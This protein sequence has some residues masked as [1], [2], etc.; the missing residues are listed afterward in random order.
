MASEREIVKQ[1]ASWL[2]L[3]EVSGPFLSIPVLMEAFP[4]GLEQTDQESELRRRLRLAYDEW[5]DNQRGARPERAI[6]RAWLRFVLDEVLGFRPDA[7]LEGQQIP[8][9]LS[10]AARDHGETVRPDLVLQSPFERQ[11]RLLIQL[12]PPA[13]K[14]D[15]VVAEQRWKASPAT[16]MMELL[17]ASNVRLGLITNGEH[18]MLIDAPPNETTGYYSWYA[19]LWLEEPLTLRAFRSLLGMERF[20]NVPA[21]Q[22]LEQL[23]TKSAQKQQEVTDQLGDQ[24]R[25]AVEVLVQTLDRLD[26]DSQ[27]TLLQ[28]VDEKTLYEAALTVM[29]RLVFLLSAEERGL[30]LLGDPLYDENYAVSTMH[31]QLR[32]LADQHGE[33]VLGLRHDAWSRLLALFR[34]VYG[35][36]SYHDL[37][38]PAYGGHLFDPDRYAFLEGR[39]SGTS[40]R[41]TPAQPLLIDNRTVLH[42]LNALQYLQVR[43]AGGGI[44]PRRL[45]FRGL[46]IEQIGHVYEGLLDH[47]A[48]RATTTILGLQGSANVEPEATLDELEQARRKG[49]T[50]LLH[51]L[52]ERTRLSEATVQKRLAS[53]LN[54][55]QERSRLMEACDNQQALFERVLPFAGLLRRDSF[56]NFVIV[57]PGSVYVT[58]GSDRRSTGTHYTPRSLT[59]PIV[60]HAL[61]P[62]VYHGP[63]EGLP[64]EQWHLRSAAELLDLKVC[65]FAMGSGAFLVQ[66]CRYLA[67]RLVEAWEQAEQDWQEQQQQHGTRKTI[68]PLTVPFA[69]PSQGQLEEELLPVDRDERLAVARRIVSER[70]LYGVDKNPMAVEMAKLSLWLITLAKNKPFTFLDHALRSGDSLLGASLK[71]LKQWSMEEQPATHQMSFIELDLRKAVERAFKLREQIRT[72]P[73]RDVQDTERK[74]RLL[75]EAEEAMEL[76]RLGADLLVATALKDTKQRETLKNTLHL[77]YQLLVNSYEDARNQHFT[78]MGRAPARTELQRLRNEVDA[79]LNGRRPFHWPLE[80]PEV[81]SDT[82]PNPG[83]SVIVSNPPFQGGQK[84]TGT[85][86]TDYRDYIIEYLAQGKRGSADLCAYFFLRATSLTRQKGMAA[87]LATNTIAQGDT[88]E[89]GLDQILAAGWTIPRAIPSRKWPGE[90]NLEV[91]HIWLR[92]GEWNGPYVLDDVAVE[93]ITAFLTTPGKAQGKPYVLVANANKSFQGSIVLGMG[94]VLEP[95]EAQALLAKDPRNKDVIFP[96][97]NGEDLNSRPDQSP[98]R[99]VI[100]FHDWPLERA[101]QYPDC[102]RIVREKVKPERD[103]NTFSKNARE[104]W[105]L[106]ERSRPELYSTIAGMKRVLVIALT[107][108]TLAFT[109]EPNNITFSHMLVILA[110]DAYHQFALLQSNFHLEWVF[111]NGSTLKKDQRYIPSDCFETFPFP[112]NMDGLDDIGERYYQHRQAIMLARQEGLTKT[113]NRFHDEQEMDAEIVRLREL[114]REMDEAVARAYGWHDLKLEHGFHETKQGIRYTIS[115]RARR[116]V[117]DRLLLLNHQRHA[118]EVEAGLAEEKAGKNGKAR[119]GKSGKAGKGSGNTTSLVTPAVSADETMEQ[120]SLF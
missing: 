105:W 106:Y 38:L 59:E 57:T 7:L 94:F 5:A 9:A 19:V 99:W 4:H 20:F 33:E 115:E 63:A 15:K 42:L 109:F 78:D 96:Y 87:M 49:E 46:D 76:V 50:E 58:Q 89:V 90:A 98:S 112:E 14:L 28:N 30:L 101:E 21:D 108:R 27:R 75:A 43:V 85:L 67:E 36:A 83:F 56:G 93:N 88:R 1:H 54:Q 11:P 117:L 29:M 53:A 39:S 95:E 48:R 23:L 81:F 44:E 102:M 6:H 62:L 74:A 26:K 107:S 114:H 119:T 100:N 52:Q 116:E 12:Y 80:F 104:K 86:G 47:T 35:G 10:Y 60:K 68:R 72:L 31:K 91:A 22:T 18:W 70:C 69:L 41:E 25:R 64:E 73:E 45:S 110:F 34:L 92:H 37:H 16:R 40:W 13:Q 120:G 111:I 51:L 3:I 32:E 77:D 118:Q 71:Q 2:Q 17:R 97:L 8:A 61:D 84:I 65:D 66:S 24:V 79:L 113:Y 82:L 103:R 55:P